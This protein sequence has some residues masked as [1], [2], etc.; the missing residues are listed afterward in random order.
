MGRGPLGP[1]SEVQDAGH[2]RALPGQLLR[3]LQGIGEHLRRQPSAL[4]L[5]KETKMKRTI[6]RAFLFAAGAALFLLPALSAQTPT[7]TKYVALGDSYGAGFSAGCLVAR[8]QQFSYPNTLAKQFGISDFQQPTVSDPGLPV[9]TGLKSL[10]PVTFGPISTTKTGVPTNAA[11]T[12]SYDN[13]S[14]PGAK[15][16]DVS[17]LKSS[18]DPPSGTCAACASTALADLVLRGKGSQLTQALSLNPTFITLGIIGNDLLT[19]V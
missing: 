3:A 15:A 1:L 9:C 18:A 19:A 13:L 5:I 6:A 12:R 17:D 16:G 2:G 10:I 7:F 8:N 11:L 14:I 4:V